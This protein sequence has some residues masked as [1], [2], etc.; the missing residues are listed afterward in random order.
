MYIGGNDI[1]DDDDN[2][3]EE[4]IVGIRDDVFRQRQRQRLALQ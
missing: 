1:N 2:D 3:N 4:E